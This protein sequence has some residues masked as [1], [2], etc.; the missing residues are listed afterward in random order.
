MAGTAP[1]LRAN[2][3]PMKAN[4]TRSPGLGIPET[5]IGAGERHT[6]GCSMTWTAGAPA[7]TIVGTPP[8]LFPGPFDILLT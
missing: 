2:A 4:R 5:C 1:K 7:A 6:T 8:R 3:T